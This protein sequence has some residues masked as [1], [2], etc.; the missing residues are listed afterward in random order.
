MIASIT[1]VQTFLNFL[2]NQVSI[3][4]G[5]SQISEL[6]HISRTSV[7][8]FY[9]MILPCILVMRHNTWALFTDESYCCYLS[10]Q[11]FTVP[12]NEQWNLRLTRSNH[13]LP[14][15]LLGGGGCL[16]V[17]VVCMHIA[18]CISCI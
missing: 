16:A 12:L 7:T 17:L 11:K 15:L 13:Y 1:R 14:R 3:C 18:Y 9:V 6:F 4:Y 10:T 5:C 2:L 8:Y